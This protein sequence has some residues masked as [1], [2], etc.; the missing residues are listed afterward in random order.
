MKLLH[1]KSK[2]DID[3]SLLPGIPDRLGNHT[4]YF[5]IAMVEDS[6]NGYVC[7]TNQTKDQVW[8]EKFSKLQAH[9]QFHFGMLERIENEQ[10]FAAVHN[11]LIKKEVLDESKN[12]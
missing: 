4:G 10:E 3:Y 7:F 8:I 2:D 9:G 5:F 12:D 11:F 6:G 1:P